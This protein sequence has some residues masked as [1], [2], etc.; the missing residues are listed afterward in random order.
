M[1]AIWERL[2]QLGLSSVTMVDAAPAIAVLPHPPIEAH[3]DAVVPEPFKAAAADWLSWR[4][5][6]E[7]LFHADGAPCDVELRLPLHDGFEV[8]AS[9][10]HTGTL[11]LGV[12]V[13]RVS[14]GAALPWP[15]AAARRLAHVLAAELAPRLA[16][17]LEHER[18]FRQGVELLQLHL[19]RQ[20]PS[21]DDVALL[22]AER[23]V[24]YEHTFHGVVHAEGVGMPFLGRVRGGPSPAGFV[25][26]VMT[27]FGRWLRDIP[28]PDPST[29]IDAVHTDLLELLEPLRTEIEATVIVPGPGRVQV[30]T[31]DTL[32]AVVGPDGTIIDRASPDE[33]TV[34]GGRLG[35]RRTEELIAPPGSSVVAVGGLADLATLRALMAAA[36]GPA[37]PPL[38]FA[39]QLR[40]QVAQRTTL[41]GGVLVHPLAA[42]ADGSM[43]PLHD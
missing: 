23:R 20:G 12:L 32:V 7:L 9:P 10:L 11:A 36:G 26:V 38:S 6:T 18:T 16:E 40:S 27:L 35:V 8:V 13:G 2:E 17:A 34:A 39:S 31:T 43:P 19:Q 4:C 25:P 14:C 1:N 21:C 29:V 33:V 22:G 24:E 42:S 15:I 5:R 41:T 30:S 37:Q 28:D 3:L